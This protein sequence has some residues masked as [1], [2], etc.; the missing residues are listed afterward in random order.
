MYDF[1]KELKAIKIFNFEEKKGSNLERKIKEFG[2][3]VSK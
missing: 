2:S 3:Y 1:L